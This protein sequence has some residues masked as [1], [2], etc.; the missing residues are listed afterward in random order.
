MSSTEALLRA[1]FGPEAITRSLGENAMKQRWC[2]RRVMATSVPVVAIVMLAGCARLASTHTVYTSNKEEILSTFRVT[3]NSPYQLTQDCSN[4]MGARRTIRIADKKIKIAGAEDGKTVLIMDAHPIRNAALTGATL[5]LY[6][7]QTDEN[8]YSFF[9]VKSVL[10]NNGIHI[11]K[12]VPMYSTGSVD[13]YFL[14][15]D[16]DGYS[17]LKQYGKAR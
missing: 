7:A 16:G 4:A 17:V 8:N 13:G 9:E 1:R 3:C 6:N 10:E 15:L 11:L 12:V 5:F 14:E 2:L